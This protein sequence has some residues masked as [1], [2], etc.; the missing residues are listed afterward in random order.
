M[1]ITPRKGLEAR[2]YVYNNL[3]C[4]PVN[5][6]SSSSHSSSS[7]SGSSN[8][9]NNNNLK[10]CIIIFGFSFCSLLFSVII[11]SGLIIIL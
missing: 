4:V 8:S 1:N 11:R 3:D 7:S 9:N 5:N 6:S 2:N 10:I